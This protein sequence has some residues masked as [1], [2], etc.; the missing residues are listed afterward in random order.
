MD[1]KEEAKG[2]N[3]KE[4]VEDSLSSNKKKV[5]DDSQKSLII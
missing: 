3:N 2:E 1:I 5:A 4:T